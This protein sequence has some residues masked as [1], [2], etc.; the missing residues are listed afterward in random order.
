MVAY[1]YNVS[2]QSPAINYSPYRDGDMSSGWTASY[3]LQSQVKWTQDTLGPG[4]SS[5]N[6]TA[7]GAMAI[8]NFTG[9]DACA[10]GDAA[11]SDFDLLCDGTPT[12]VSY[13]PGYMACCGNL[14]MGTH[15]IT[16]KAT[17]PFLSVVPLALMGF[18]IRTE[19]PS[20]GG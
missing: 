6:T 1:R 4:I 2:D 9:T 10:I 5:H 16:L 8:L 17:S 15:S 13:P 14:S 11:R 7:S 18:N 19:L 20:T 12:H 3:T